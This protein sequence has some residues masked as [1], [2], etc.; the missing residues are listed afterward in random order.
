M[1]EKLSR[2]VPRGVKIRPAR[3]NRVG[4]IHKRVVI[5][6]GQLSRVYLEIRYTRRIFFMGG[7]RRT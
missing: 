1:L 3:E 7:R 5:A 6:L 2:Y 4:G